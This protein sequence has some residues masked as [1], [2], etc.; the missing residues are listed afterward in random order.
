MLLLFNDLFIAYFSLSLFHNYTK[1]KHY[2]FK[3]EYVL[4][5]YIVAFINNFISQ[6]NFHYKI[7]PINIG[8]N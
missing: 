6:S 1:L 5:Y 2:L 3:L 7:I 8:E 4:L